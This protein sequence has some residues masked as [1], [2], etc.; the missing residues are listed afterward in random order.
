MGCYFTSQGIIN[1]K[2]GKWKNDFSLLDTGLD[3]YISNFYTKAYLRHLI[4][5]KEILGMQ[6]ASIQNLT[7]YLWLM[8]QAREKILQNQF[9]FWKSK[10][11]KIVSQRL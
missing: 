7:F 9:A 11:I 8:R 5:S 2:N 1:I 3:G 4:L 10:M 6:I